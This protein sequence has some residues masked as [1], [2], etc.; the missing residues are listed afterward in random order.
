MGACRRIAR[1]AAGIPDDKVAPP[2]LVTGAD[3]LEMGAK[4]GPTLGRV[5]KKLYD[6]QLDERITAKR[7]ALT[8]ARG[9]LE[10]ADR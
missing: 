5:L 9:L 8:V 4:E 10:R 1:R 6:A 3:L 7:Q 2:P